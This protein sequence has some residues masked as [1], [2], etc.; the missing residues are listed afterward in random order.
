MNISINFCSLSL[1]NLFHELIDIFIILTTIEILKW[2]Q[3]NS[4]EIQSCNSNCSSF[5]LNLMKCIQAIKQLINIPSY[6][7]AL[8][9]CPNLFRI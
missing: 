1:K 4:R 7:I 8:T 6:K 2:I 5:S 3:I 9:H